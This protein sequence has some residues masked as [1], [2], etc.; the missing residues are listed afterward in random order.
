M[1]RAAVSSILPILGVFAARKDFQI[2]QGP[3]IR[4][5]D[6]HEVGLASGELGDDQPDLAVE[7]G[8]RDE[9]IQRWLDR[10]PPR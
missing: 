8:C 10:S 3:I 9:A 2:P 6:Y 1:T 7:R 4:G 5:D